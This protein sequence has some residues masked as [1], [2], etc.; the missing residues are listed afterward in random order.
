M[1]PTATGMRTA[2]IFLT[3]WTGTVLPIRNLMP[4]IFRGPSGA[5][6]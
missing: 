3:F 1:R 6:I 2:R 4:R 5:M